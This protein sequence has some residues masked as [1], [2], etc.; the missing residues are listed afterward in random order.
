[1]GTSRRRTPPAPVSTEPP[2]GART[3]Y[4][5]KQ[6]ISKSAFGFK[7]KGRNFCPRLILGYLIPRTACG[8][9]TPKPSRSRRGNILAVFRSTTPRTYVFRRLNAAI[10]CRPIRPIGRRFR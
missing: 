9:R 6:K 3:A 7:R 10:Q 1:M 5:G 4:R 8:G 2:K